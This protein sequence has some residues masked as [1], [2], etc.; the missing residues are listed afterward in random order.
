MLYVSHSP[1]EVVRL[2][3]H[4]VMLG[5]GR[6]MAAGELH[7]TMARLDLPT[8]FTEDA[9]VV[10]DGTVAAHDDHYHLT[11]LDFPGGA[12]WVQRQ[13][14]ALG[15]CLRFR[16]H[17]RDVSLADHRV[18]GSSIQ[19][20][21]P[22]TVE[23][24]VG[25]DTPA[26]VLVR[27]GR[28]RHRADGPHHPPRRRA[29]RAAPGAADVGADQVGGAAGLRSCHHCSPFAHPECVAMAAFL[30]S[31]TPMTM[32]L[33]HCINAR[34]FRVLWMLEE[35][36]LPYELK[37][38]PFPPRSRDE[39]YLEVNPLGTIPAFLDGDVWMSESAAICQYLAARHSPHALDVGVDEADFGAYLQR[40]CI[41]ARPR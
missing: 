30:R 2:A 32:T 19:N 5:E 6:V 22:A 11:R 20:L 35:L 25:A 1:D 9:G 10:I 4:V 33:Y 29:A 3:D 17:A 27:P 41:S 16:I 31:A 15:R 24:V 23:E 37:V 36:G 12:V 21:L 13:A 18:E 34:S 39:Q 7:A 38:L 8:A 14:V 28:R 40:V 26:H